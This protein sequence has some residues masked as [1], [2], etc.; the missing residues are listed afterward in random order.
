MPLNLTTAREYLKL[1]L[2]R[3]FLTNPL[4]APLKA[5]FLVLFYGMFS[6]IIGFYS[7]MLKYELISLKLM[8]FLLV[9]LFIFPSLL[10]EAF[11]RG[12]LIPMETITQSANQIIFVI[13]RSALLFVLW[14]PFNAFLFNHDAIKFFYDPAFLLIVAALGITCSYSY[15]ISKSIWIPVLIHWVTVI[16]W[17]FFFGGRNMLLDM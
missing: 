4:K 12:I 5:W 13:T 1:N 14:H 8:P 6:L 11:F 2:L 16:I 15:I 9:T 3:G 17:V 10:E 7:G